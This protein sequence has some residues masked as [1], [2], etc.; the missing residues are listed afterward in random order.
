MAKKK[1]GRANNGGARKGAGAPKKE[2][3]EHAKEMMK[4]AVRMLYNKDSDEEAQVEFLK[5][6]AQTSRGQQFLA[7]HLFGK[8]T[9]HTDI[10]SNGNSI[11][12]PT[13]KFVGIDDNN[14]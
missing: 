12:T 8:P 6:F 10:T 3:S 4:K 5:E 1:D 13:I 2:V 11:N 9:E 14:K 7:E